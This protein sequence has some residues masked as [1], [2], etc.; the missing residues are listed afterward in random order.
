M[1]TAVT[2]W[3]PFHELG[4][5]RARF[6]R[7]FE[8]IGEGREGAWL[9]AVDVSRDDG[10]LVIKADLPGI[11]P[12]DVTINGGQVEYEADGSWELV[13]SER[14]PGRP[15]WVRTQGHPTGLLWF[16]WFLPT[17]TPAQPTCEVVT[18]P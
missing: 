15:N 11:S 7:M 10:N 18:L 4:E 12:D 14:D 5:L 9:P 3:D 13:V 1:S 8:D 16:R 17:E 2:R 6:N